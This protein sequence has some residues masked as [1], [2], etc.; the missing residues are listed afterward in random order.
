MSVGT[1]SYAISRYSMSL[2]RPQSILPRNRKV[3][4]ATICRSSASLHIILCSADVTHSVPAPRGILCLCLKV[5]CAAAVRFY[6]LAP[7][8]ILRWRRNLFCAAAARNST[9]PVQSVLLYLWKIFYASTIRYSVPAFCTSIAR[10]SVPP[11]QFVL[12]RCGKA[13]CVTI[14]KYSAPL[15]Q[16]IVRYHRD[17]FCLT[18]IMSVVRP[19]G[20]LLRCRSMVRSRHVLRPSCI[21][22]QCCEVT[23]EMLTQRCRDVCQD[24]ALTRNPRTRLSK[25]GHSVV[26]LCIPQKLFSPTLLCFAQAHAGKTA[27]RIN[28][29]ACS[30]SNFGI[31]HSIPLSLVPFLPTSP[32]PHPP[33]SLSPDLATLP[34]LPTAP[35]FPTSS[36]LPASSALHFRTSTHPY[37]TTSPLPHRLSSTRSRLAQV[38]AD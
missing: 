28:P 34:H 22:D 23:E 9:P 36:D 11:V 32:T 20:C 33:P 5:F 35:C 8:W 13:F 21:L 24:G 14:A 30:W 38:S 7:L 4:C 31:A 27:E 1:A 17:V 6:I 12:R 29:N 25:P 19:P 26:Q 10:Y 3:I 2:P 18:A 37:L 16:G 15:S